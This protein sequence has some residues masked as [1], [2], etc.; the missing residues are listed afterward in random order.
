MPA[1]AVRSEIPPIVPSVP[2]VERIRAAEPR[3]FA[4]A[5]LMLVAMAPTGFAAFADSRELLGVDIWLKPL[6]FEF[7]LFAYLMTLAVFALFLPGEIRAKRWYRLYAGAVSV[8]AVVEIV[9]LAGASAIGAP[10]HFNPTPA[11]QAIYAAMGATAVLITSAS[12]VYAFH[13][14]RNPATGLSPA[15]KESLVLGLA[16]VLPLTLMTAGTMS[17]MSSHFIGGTPDDAGGLPVMGWSRDGGDLRAAH[18]FATHALHFVPAFGLLSAS[19]F[20]PANRTPV[21]LFAAGFALFV[22][23]L[24]VQALLGLPVL[25]SAG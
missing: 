8:G 9:W 18:F 5:L 14:A 1:L 11:G 16:L 17:Q 7:A 3:F 19:L 15:L 24:L 2:L 23:F 10:S 25:P 12:A 20:G 21:R 4:T 13:I 6:K 22:L